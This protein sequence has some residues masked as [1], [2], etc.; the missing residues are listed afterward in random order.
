LVPRLGQRY[1]SKYLFSAKLIA[2]D[3]ALDDCFVPYE[4]DHTAKSTEYGADGYTG[5]L[6]DWHELL[7]V[8]APDPKCGLV[9]VRGSFPSTPE[10]ILSRAQRE[11]HSGAKGTWG[12]D[13]LPDSDFEL[14]GVFGQGLL[15]S[16]WP[17]IRY[18]IIPKQKD[19][20]KS[21]A[22][23]PYSSGTCESLS[24]VKDRVVYQVVRLVPG[25][26]RKTFVP[27]PP[28]SAAGSLK[29]GAASDKAL[30][31]PIRQNSIAPTHNEE[32]ATRKFR[33]RVGG[34]IRFG[35]TCDDSASQLLVYTSDCDS[36][37]GW[38]SCRSDFYKQNLY[39]RTFINGKPA[40]PVRQHEKI[41]TEKPE[42]LS[43]PLSRHPSTPSSRPQSRPSSRPQSRPI[44]RPPSIRSRRSTSPEI[45]SSNLKNV[46]LASDFEIHIDDK[47]EMQII[48]IAIALRQDIEKLDPSAIEVP[49]S[50]D[51]KAFLGISKESDNATNILWME[52]WKAK[53]H[54]ESNIYELRTVM[55]GV[56]R[57]LGVTSMPVTEK[58][59][60]SIS[61]PKS[62]GWSSYNSFREEGSMSGSE[63][64]KRKAHASNEDPPL[65]PEKAKA[66]EIMNTNS[67]EFGSAIALYGN[68]ASPIHVDLG[69][70]LYV[71][72]EILLMLNC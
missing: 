12:F 63:M 16:R 25:E 65:P 53:E 26:K 5:S 45:Y 58:D 2:T 60:D 11:D 44:S 3:A 28:G 40:V 18:T 27:P 47:E 39:I 10:A 24:F 55:T 20:D 72:P 57:I 46:D 6:T 13:M 23:R 62:V 34:K 59:I 35:C 43:R 70:S 67:G 52:R 17:Y 54:Q 9:F 7:Q 14:G 19:K 68:I 15:N 33:F 38:S 48:V 29:S 30:E 51:V 36:R 64:A 31:E 37:E 66:I 8:T 71:K 49:S 4:W 69:S 56:E 21:R 41:T 1:A 50:S 32:T 61:L 22:F 42:R